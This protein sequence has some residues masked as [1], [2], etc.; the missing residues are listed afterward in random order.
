[1]QGAADGDT[2][3][4][5]TATCFA[6]RAAHLAAFE[7]AV[8]ATEGADPGIC[9]TLV[10]P[11]AMVLVSLACSVGPPRTKGERVSWLSTGCCKSNPARRAILFSNSRTAYKVQVTSLGIAMTRAN[12]SVEREL[13]RTFAETHDAAHA[14]STYQRF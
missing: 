10:P 6:A 3:S 7:P 8:L 1:M 11:A 9:D 2:A 12:V 4:E 13:G 5:D 14:G